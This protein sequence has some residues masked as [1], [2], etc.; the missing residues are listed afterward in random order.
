MLPNTDANTHVLNL[1]PN[2]PQINL[3]REVQDLMQELY[4]VKLEHSELL[5]ELEHEEYAREHFNELIERAQGELAEQIVR[6]PP[7]ISCLPDAFA[8]PLPATRL[9][10]S[11]K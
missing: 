5:T 9:F 1:A 11:A 10:V 6:V 7:P 2:P 3:R 8:C 4:L